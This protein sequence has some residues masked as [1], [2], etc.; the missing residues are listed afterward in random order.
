MTDRVIDEGA[1]EAATGFVRQYVHYW[2]NGVP[3]WSEADVEGVV[4][5]YSNAIEG[6]L[7]AYLNALPPVEG[8]VVEREDPSQVPE[9]PMDLPD[10]TQW[11]ASF[12]RMAK[13]LGYSDMDEDWLVGWFAN[14]MMCKSDYEARLREGPVPEGRGEWRPIETAP[15][16]N[17][18]TDSGPDILGYGCGRAAVTFALDAGDQEWRMAWFDPH[19]NGWQPTHWRPLPIPPGSEGG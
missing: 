5:I 15:T 9:P 2:A 3:G 17:W 1:L 18:E 8:P 12:N 10:A 16:D 13:A 19:D 7:A 4:S 11:A 6:A 14:A